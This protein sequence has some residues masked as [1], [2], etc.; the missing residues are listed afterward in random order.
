MIQTTGVMTPTGTPPIHADLLT[1]ALKVMAD[2]RP[3]YTVGATDRLANFKRVAERSGISPQQVWLVY[4][5]KHIDAIQS[6]MTKPELPVSEAP[7]GRFIDAINYLLLGYELWA[8]AQPAAPSGITSRATDWWQK[9][10]HSIPS[11]TV[12]PV[13]GGDATLR[14]IPREWRELLNKEAIGGGGGL[15][16]PSRSFTAAASGRAEEDAF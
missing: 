16:G 11:T 14:D 9:S 15:R 7:K 8:E 5:L 2:K 6:I 10:T 3:G 4:F 13:A 1:E 12:T